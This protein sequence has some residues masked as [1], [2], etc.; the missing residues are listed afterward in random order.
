MATPPQEWLQ[1]PNQN[2][3]VM[4]NC[5]PQPSALPLKQKQ[6]PRQQLRQAPGS[7]LPVDATLESATLPRQRCWQVA[8]QGLARPWS[9]VAHF[10]I[11]KRSSLLREKICAQTR[12]TLLTK[13]TRKA[14]SGIISWRARKSAYTQLT[15]YRPHTH[16]L[17]SEHN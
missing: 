9:L 14:A 13:T 1:M 17:C 16:V 10:P 6:R 15:I 7:F 2:R 5:T 11:L 3:D 8:C 12:F 4:A